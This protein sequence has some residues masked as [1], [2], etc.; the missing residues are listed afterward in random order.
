M[1]DITESTTQSTDLL[2][3]VLSRLKVVRGS[4][5]QGRYVCWCCFHPDGKGKKP[6]QPNLHVS[7]LGHYCFACAAKGSLRDLARHSGLQPVSSA[8]HPGLCGAVVGRGREPFRLAEYGEALERKNNTWSYVERTLSYIRRMLEADECGFRH[9]Q[10]IDDQNVEEYLGRLREEGLS[11]STRNH[12]VRALKSFTAW[13]VRTRRTG[14]N[15]LACLSFLKADTDIRRERRALRGEETRRLLAAAERGPTVLGMS[16]Q[17]RALCYRVALT[18]GLRRKELRSLTWQSLR[19]GGPRPQVTVEAGSSKHRRRD[20]LPL[21]PD[22]AGALR[23]WQAE[24]PGDGLL[25]PLPQRTAKML[26]V[27]LRAAGIDYRDDRG[28]VIDFHALRH[29][30]ITGLTRGGAYTR[31]SPRSWHGTAPSA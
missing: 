5:D 18:T 6:H 12:H 9:A 3:E 25:F 8:D 17:L 4:D 20:V 16:G 7:E 27:D 29:T 22:V 15:R 28:R 13:L 26:R 21:R 10:D 11:I 14:K 24:H 30:F 2:R 31:R 1:T 23:R 19:L